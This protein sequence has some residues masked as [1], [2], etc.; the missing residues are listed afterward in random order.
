MASRSNCADGLTASI[1]T[2]RARYAI[3]DY[4]SSEEGRSP[5]AAHMVGAGRGP[6]GP[7]HWQDLQL[8]LYRHLVADLGLEGEPQLGFVTLAADAGEN[9]LS[10]GRLDA[11]GVVGGR[12]S[13]ARVSCARFATGSFGHR[14]T[15]S[16]GLIRAW[17]GSARSKSSTGSWNRRTMP[18][19][20]EI[21]S[22]TSPPR[23][24][25][26]GHAG[27]GHAEP[28]GPD[29][30][31]VII[32]ASAGT[33]KTFQLSNRYLQLVLTGHSPERILATTFT[34]KA[35]GEIL[36]RILL[37]LATA[38]EGPDEA[39]STGRGTR[40]DVAVRSTIVDAPCAS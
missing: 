21:M 17:T 3:L 4:K 14:P 32:R 10:T 16:P 24:A 30:P 12:R 20:G 5:R 22:G 27:D 40:A 35:A 11:S 18:R 25:G 26:A 19:P 29:P 1:N 28:M 23:D 7:E 34:R 6:V 15:W 13:G 8:P 39:R 31:H 38:A 2:N 36:D 33:G 37:R 9:R